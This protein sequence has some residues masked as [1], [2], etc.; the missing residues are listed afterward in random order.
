MLKK[1]AKKQTEDMLLRAKPDRRLL[2]H[3]P[4]PE[5]IRR[6]R[7]RR[8]NPEE[9]PEGE[10]ETKHRQ[11]PPQYARFAG[12]RYLSRFPV[13]LRAGA[14]HY[15]AESIDISQ[16]GVLL[17]FPDGVV[18]DLQPGGGNCH[19]EFTIPSG[20]MH[21]GME[22]HYRIS[23]VPIRS[24][25]EKGQY[26]F[27]FS[28]PLYRYLQRRKDNYLFTMSAVF[29]F[30]VS[31]F[32]IMLRTESVLYF[33]F[34][35]ALYLYSIVAATFLLS[36]YLFGAF[37]K[38]VPIDAT[39]R[40]SV[41]V[42]IPCYNEEKWI[43]RTIMSC[44]DQ[45][46][47]VDKLEL[48]IVDDFSTDNSVSVI[49]DTVSRLCAED[50]RFQTQERIRVFLQKTNKGKRE[51][52]AL[53]I[54]NARSDLVVFVDSDSFLE[55]D[56]IVNLVQPFSDPKVAGVSGRT[57]VANA[58]TNWLTKTQAVRYYIAF[59]I[60][61]AAEA[62]FDSV[63]CLSGPLSAYRKSEV[64]KVLGKW[65]NQTFVGHRATFGDDRSLTNFIVRNNRTYYQDTAICSTIVPKSNNLFLKQQM[66]WKRSW[67]RESLMAARFMWKKEP[68][69]SLSFY[70]GLVI[71]V[72]APVIVIYNLI[73]IPIVHRVFPTTFLLGLLAMAL[74]MS[75][76]QLLLKKS[77]LWLYGFWFCVYYEAVLLWQMPWAWVTFWVSTWGTRETP[78][79]TKYKRRRELRR[80]K[81]RFLRVE[82]ARKRNGVP[83]LGS[84]S[85]D[86]SGDV[87][88]GSAER[89][90]DG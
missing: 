75:F 10:A 35:K 79:D 46:Y 26:A 72:A 3:V 27:Q 69:M 40:P 70:M 65:V 28:E 43:R 22:K 37:Y 74:M 73:Y 8:G 5:H 19:L 67:L 32:I 17:Q 29:L 13:R 41:T 16:T 24:D 78:Q 47:P 88:S 4:D 14:Q 23:A 85:G 62:Y 33:R 59:R 56:A 36:R 51:A 25:A 42:I 2:A 86:V 39:F 49:K 6:K 71:P 58:Y 34:N 84:V 83:P 87:G 18:P 60:L 64:V 12:Q 53:G 66:R 76:A 38:P 80:E 77:K 7:D 45:D 30:C 63:M 50:E 9:P 55:P 20:F 68:L 52:M 90:I 15:D 21:E 57:D 11:A 44:I 1:R 54:L 82:R 89:T 48:I 81:R 31:L 61:K